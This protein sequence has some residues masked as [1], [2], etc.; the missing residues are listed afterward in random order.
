MFVLPKIHPDMAIHS[1]RIYRLS[2]AELDS[3]ARHLTFTRSSTKETTASYTEVVEL[4]RKHAEEKE[5]NLP[6]PDQITEE[7]KQ[8]YNSEYRK[9]KKA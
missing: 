8:H 7:M 5:C 3:I 6:T 1:D 4:F 9:F 2:G